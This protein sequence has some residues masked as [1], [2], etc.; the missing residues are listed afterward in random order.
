MQQCSEIS[1]GSTLP[2]CSEYLSSIAISRCKVLQLI[3]DLDPKKAGGSDNISVHMIK[4]CN[5]S[6]IELLCLIFEKSLNT[7]TYPSA[8][9]EANIVPIH[10]KGSRQSKFNY[11]P[12]SLLPTFGKIFERIIFDEI[13]QHLCENGLLV[14]Q[15]SGFRPGDSTINQLLSIT[16][17]IYKAFEA[18]P[19]LETRTV[20]LD[21][22]KAFDRV[23]HEG[24]LF[25]LKCNGVNENLFALIENYLTCRK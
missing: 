18:C 6:V 22:S 11:R 12:I 20:F 8:W 5:A 10:K 17:N 7:G 2:Q 21:I 16:Q 13:Y 19:T 4:I 9:K 25:K 1:T 24:L 3:R 14:Q 15:Q 23:W